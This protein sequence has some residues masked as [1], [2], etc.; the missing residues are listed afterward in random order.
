MLLFFII[1]TRSVLLLFN[2]TGSKSCRRSME[3]GCKSS[4]FS[5]DSTL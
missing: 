2:L 1:D 5:N 4:N 3:F